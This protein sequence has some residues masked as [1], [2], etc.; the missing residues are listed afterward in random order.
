MSIS[1]INHNKYIVIENDNGNV[2]YKLASGSPVIS[3]K[4]Y[5]QLNGRYK[6]KVERVG[7]GSIIKI[8]D[9]TP[10]PENKKDVI[11]PHFVEL[12]WANGCNFNCAWCYLNGTFRFRPMGKCPYLKD[13]KKILEHTNAFI[14]GVKI[15]TILNS[16]ELADSLVFEGNG[17]SLSNNVIPLFKKQT[18]HKL[19]FLTKSININGILNSG[20]KK[21]TIASFTVNAFNVSE[22]WERGA[23]NPMQRI[24]AASKLSDEGYETRLRIDPLVPIKNWK[25]RYIELIDYIFN[26]FTPER[27]TLGSLRGLQST[28]NN[29]KDT[30]WVEYLDENSNWGKKISIQKRYNMYKVIIDYLEKEYKYSNLGLCKETK[31][32][33]DMIGK[34]YRKIK[35]NCIK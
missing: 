27:I 34:D 9:R 6:Y 21:Q 16:G 33:W 15:P 19:L 31:E 32:M 17:F 25:E 24:S 12:K 30:S 28:I 20:S 11:C 7:D 26:N 3:I 8:F 5:K 4:K 29:C 14:D 22:R 18:K 13:K 2:R 35:C 23:P 10:F 1:W